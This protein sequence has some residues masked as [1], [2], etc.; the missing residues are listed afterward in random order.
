MTCSTPAAERSLRRIGPRACPPAVVA[1]ALGLA[2]AACAAPE[3]GPRRPAHGHPQPVYGGRFVYSVQDDVRTLDPAIGYDTDSWTAEH[4][5]FDTLLT[6]D[7]DVQLAPSLATSW[8]LADDGVTWTFQLRDDVRFH[9]GRS[10]VAQDVVDSWNRLFE[11]SLASP[12]TDFYGIIDGADDVLAGRAQRLSGLVALDDH[13]LQV[14]LDH[15]DSTFLD[16]TAMM[17]G[18]VVPVEVADQ[19]GERFAVTPVGT[20]PFM[21]AER[22]LGERTLFVRAPDH[23]EAGLPYL[24]EI[25]LIA[26]YTRSLQFMKLENDELHQVDRLTSPDYLWLK[27]NPA[28]A[29][30]LVEH[31]NVDTYGEL[32]NT[33]LPPFDDVWFRRAVSTAIDRDKLHKLRNGRMRTTVSWVPP[34]LDGF[35]DW[36]ALSEEERADFQYQRYDPDL[37]RACLARSAWSQGPRDPVVYWAIDTEGSLV[38]ALSIQQDLALAG[39]PMELKL[40]N[41]NTYYTAT[42]MRR[43]VPFAYGAWVMDFPHQRNFLEPRFHSR[44][45]AEENSTND[46]FYSN[47][48]VDDLL[49]RAARSTDPEQARD[50]YW[51]AHRIIARDV[52]YL[53]EYHSLGVSVT[54]PYVKGFRA[55][56]VYNRDMREAWLDLPSGRTTP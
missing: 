1:A 13:T 56:P 55:H 6:Y 7:D 28:W 20:G 51:Q 39:I 29:A 52:P 26:G 27:R 37:S 53:F 12:A 54:Q 48:Q 25:E 46:S 49:D 17:F 22:T 34:A 43:T 50:L 30:Q 5:V 38:T 16:V 40:V 32:M 2:L 4:L 45:I 36:D 42:G 10:M 41:Q 35:A 14:T 23:W 44:M 47:P 33:E 24:D 31:E 21:V 11:P 15:P 8:S 18:A 19:L 9:H 3:R